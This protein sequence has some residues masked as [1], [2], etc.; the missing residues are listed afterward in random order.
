MRLQDIR[1]HEKIW[2]LFE[3]IL[4]HGWRQEKLHARLM[5]DAHKY[6]EEEGMTIVEAIDLGITLGS[7]GDDLYLYYWHDGEGL[8]IFAGE[9]RAVIHDLNMVLEDQEGETR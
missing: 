7:E 6:V 2:P 4:A 5:E 3:R 9:E 8:W 1:K